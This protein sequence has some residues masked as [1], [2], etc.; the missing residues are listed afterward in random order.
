MQTERTI[1]FRIDADTLVA[2]AEITGNAELFKAFGYFSQW[3]LNHAICEII[4]GVYDG[5]PEIIATYRRDDGGPITYQIG[6]VW[7]EG[8][9]IDGITGEPVAGHFGFHS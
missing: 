8:K 5:N 7:H 4:G 6:A 2:I 3:N 1:K 9:G